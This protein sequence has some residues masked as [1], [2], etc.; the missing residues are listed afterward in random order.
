VGSAGT[1]R[2]ENQDIQDSPKS[3]VSL[4]LLHCLDK[5]AFITF[6]SHQTP[7]ESLLH[8][9]VVS[10]I[11]CSASETCTGFQQYRGVFIMYFIHRFQDALQRWGQHWYDSFT[12][13]GMLSVSVTCPTSVAKQQ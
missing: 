4:P 6:S 8:M 13:R 5:I 9:V 7:A 1:Q 2:S 3:T 10:Q 11:S 12:G